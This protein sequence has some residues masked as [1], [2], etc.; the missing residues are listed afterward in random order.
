MAAPYLDWSK[1]ENGETELSL[2]MLSFDDVTLLRHALEN[3]R[4]GLRDAV[5][6]LSEKTVKDF[7]KEKSS[8]V[9]DSRHVT[10]QYNATTALI[11][12]LFPPIQP[13]KL[14]IQNTHANV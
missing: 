1:N 3:Y 2:H 12:A 11:T 5:I 7:T 8:H 4:T 9:T 14:I 13:S 10:E 6:N